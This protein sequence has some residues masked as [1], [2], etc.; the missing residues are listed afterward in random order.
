MVFF[1]SGRFL[2][3]FS[4]VFLA[5]KMGGFKMVFVMYLWCFYGL[6]VFRWFLLCFYGFFYGLK[7]FRWFFPMVFRW[8]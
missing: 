6:K 2:K 3:V 5:R 7:V 4:R 1:F 8:F